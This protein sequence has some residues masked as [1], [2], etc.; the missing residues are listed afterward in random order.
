VDN[1]KRIYINSMRP[2][3][4]GIFLNPFIEDLPDIYALFFRNQIDEVTFPQ[5]CQLPPAQNN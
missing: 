1:K 4:E 5:P 2:L 3:E